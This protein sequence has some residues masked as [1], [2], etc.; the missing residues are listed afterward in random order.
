MEAVDALS[1]IKENRNIGW[2]TDYPAAKYRK[3]DF[4]H[5]SFIVPTHYDIHYYTDVK[6]S[7]S[8]V[9]FWTVSWEFK[10]REDRNEE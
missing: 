1:F 5:K 3:R 9:G 7:N 6:G 4:P 2:I 8:I 10:D